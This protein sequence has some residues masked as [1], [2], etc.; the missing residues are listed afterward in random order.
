MKILI[1]I[2]SF[3]IIQTMSFAQEKPSHD[4]LHVKGSVY[5]IRVDHPK[6]GNPSSVASIGEEGVF[7]ADVGPQG[8][9][10]M[11]LN[12]LKELGNNNVKYIVTTH[13]HGDH[14]EGLEYFSKMENVTL[15]S[16]TKQRTYLGSS[17][18]FL[19]GDTHKESTLPKITFDDK[20][21]VYINNEEIEIFTGINTNGH[22][23]GDA[24]IYFK[25]SDVLYLGDYVFLN[26][27]PIIDLNNGGSID[28]FL[29]NMKSI[30]SD[31]SDETIIVPGHGTLA[32]NKIELLTVKDLKVYYENLRESV[33]W[34]RNEIK[35][36]K[37]LTEIQDKG[38]PIKFDSFN[39]NY[40]Y[41]SNKRWIKIVCEDYNLFAPKILYS[42]LKD[43]NW[44]IYSITTESKT[45]NRITNDS[46]KD[47]QS[48][49]SKI[50]N[51]IVFDSYRDDNT[52]NLFTYNVSSGKITQLTNLNTRD[53]HPVWSPDGSKIAFQSSRTGNPEIFIMDHNG[54]NVK[55]LTF[56]GKFDGIPKWSPNGKLLAFNS[57]RDGNPNV[58]T[59][60][61]ETQELL[62]IT[63]NESYN[64]IQD[65]VSQSEI[66]IITDVLKKR[67][68]Q[69]LDIKEGITK[70]LVTAGNLT[71]ARCNNIGQIVFTEKAADGAFDIYLM[72]IKTE[73]VKR[74]T[75]SKN[76]KRFPSFMK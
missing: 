8:Y 9:E 31:F 32:P 1:T 54:T 19:N 36:G 74:L 4:T 65:W 45:I 43:N 66:L 40:I 20:I 64:F 58:F 39:E 15:I 13:H 71:Y 49:Y 57:N 34:V 44:D 18:I 26:H 33:D 56:N 2:F 3:I 38:L 59:L 14:T 62:Q 70:T 46:L 35:S 41:I 76:E 67:Q 6:F 21:T 10:E 61:L 29:D 50:N 68:M 52:R 7:L 42:E 53:G 60:N 5:T 27:F 22:T 17:M 24:F 30:L 28:G 72:D 37:T 75:D 12:K 47:F 69:I 25:T 23:G 48:D 55:Q 51:S 73:E 63:S 16:P 11:L